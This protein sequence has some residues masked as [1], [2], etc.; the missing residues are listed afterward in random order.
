MIRYLLGDRDF[1]RS[2]HTYVADNRERTVQTGDL[3]DAI[4]KATGKN[5]ARF[6]D[7]WVYGGG[8]PEY[9]VRYWWDPK[10]KKAHVRVVQTQNVNGETALFHLPVEFAFETADGEI[11]FKETVDKRSHLFTFDLPSEPTMVLFDPD[12]W[13]LK[14]VDF[15]KSEALWIRQL[16]SARHPEA[17]VEAA[18]ALG[19]I[20]GPAATEALAK[21]LVADTFW[22]VQGEIAQALGGI[23]TVAAG[24]A[25]AEGHQRL[26]HPKARR[27]LIAALGELRDPVFISD[28]RQGA[29]A[30]KSY[31]AANQSLKS[32]AKLGDD[33]V[34]SLARAAL[35]SESWNHTLRVG[36]LEALT[37]LRPSNLI[38]VLTAH[39]RTDQPNP[40]RMAAARC[41]AH[42]GAGRSDV[43][44]VLIKL[45]EDPF[46]LLQMTAVRGL[47][48]IGD[49]RA[50]PVLKRLS[51]GDRDGRLKR[52][53]EEVLE[54]IRKHIEPEDKK[55]RKKV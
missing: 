30:E 2:I 24:R 50:V 18:R 17:R 6:F 33:E 28:L 37:T 20:G 1:W 23:R 9:K 5:L 45:A 52:T 35:A 22:W 42:V 3:L 51:E 55:K 8:H 41:L 14:K 47:G 19:K 29:T 16:T 4:Q 48:Q 44:D 39:T 25:L 36:A 40:V 34:S 10:G 27:L 31:S 21:A 15:A 7:Q 46:L 54:K 32:L 53:A 49:E 11:R 13:L 26:E 12:G 43:Q 38:G